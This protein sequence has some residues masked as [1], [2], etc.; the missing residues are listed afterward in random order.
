MEEKSLV[1]NT[2]ANYL[3]LWGFDGDVM[4]YSDQSL[5]AVFKL[6]P[7]DVSCAENDVINIIKAQL[8]NFL[9]SLDANLSVQFFQ[10]ITTGHQDILKAHD[11]LIQENCVPLYKEMTLER[12]NKLA[13]RDSQGQIPR[14]DLYFVVRRPIVKKIRSKFNIGEFLG[15]N[16]K[17][18]IQEEL[19]K[20]L[21]AEVEKFE[22]KLNQ[23]SS[24]LLGCG[25]LSERM[26]QRALYDLFYSVWN[27]DRPIEH[28][29][30]INLETQDVRDSLIL[31][32]AVAG[33]DAFSLGKFR[34]K[35]ITLKN[36][37]EVT[38]ASMAEELKNLPVD[39]SL[40]VSIET[41]ETQKE[42]EALKL[43]QQLT[44][45]MVAGS[46]GVSDVES[47]AKLKE[48]DSLME[49]MIS[50]SERV[51]KV[52]VQVIIKSDSDEHLEQQTTEV[53][54][55]I[56]SLSGAEA[57]VETLAAFPIFCD[58]MPPNFK[59][60]ERVRRMNSSV[61]ADFLPVYG[62]WSGHQ[63][64]RVLLRNQ[65]SGLIGFDPFS[66]TL[67]NY[68]QVISGGSGSGK[69]FLTSLIVNQM[70]KENPKVIMIDIGGSYERICRLLDGQYVPLGLNQGLS[71]NPFD[72]SSDDPAEF[73]NKIKFLL[74]LVEI[75]TKE[76]DS[77]ALGKL[78]R[79]ELERSIVDVLRDS[80]N[81]CLS[82]LKDKL[83]QHHD[84]SLVRL[85]KILQTWCED[86]PFGKFVDQKTTIEL[87]KNLVCF[88]LKHLEQTPDMQAVALFIITDLVWREVQKDRTSQKIVVFDECWRLLES[89]SASE[90]I[91]SV[92]RTF[93]KYKASAVAI[94]QA[95]NDFA[96]SRVASAILPNSSVKWILKQ[97][98][99]G[100]ANLK[101]ELK[102]NDKEVALISDLRSVKGEYSAAF[103][104]CEEDRQVVRIEATPLEY[105]LATTD[106][107]DIKVLNDLA[108]KNPHLSEIEVLKLAAGSK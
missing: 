27:P 19:E 37:P 70:G 4:I 87:K 98:G 51:F 59:A 8:V 17:I 95:I 22:Q 78:E 82:K 108:Q 46:R 31:T 100:V 1:D 13:L 34:H 16:K 12:T 30:K 67:T 7:I 49:M 15:F 106:P 102:L 96:K 101:E 47:Q 41:T 52:A 36:I 89:P 11:G 68:N 65:N 58:V 20:V 76:D 71:L 99:G 35:I 24:M 2:L 25:L 9:N 85:G 83:L 72:L 38:F 57:I 86:T 54:R 56:R 6:K 75:M 40:I 77:R 21:Q 69:S 79:A 14:Q 48:I 60:K 44:Y 74:S 23:I 55:L 103:L 73:D 105:W 80:E 43:Q 93:R 107:T 66:P 26:R 42:I 33:A 91:A 63:T 84:A 88:D 97:T 28:A 32:P 18:S 3:K 94:S 104:M 45:S 90:F 62:N 64:P 61:L 53:L 92:F 81:P 50:G 39:S 5:G 10:N 29:D